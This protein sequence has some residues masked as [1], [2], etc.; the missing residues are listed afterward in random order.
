MGKKSRIIKEQKKRAAEH[1][2]APT[3]LDDEGIH[4][5]VVGQ[6]PGVLETAAI[7]EAYQE[8]IRN[9]G[10]LWDQMVKNFREQ[11]AKEMLN[12]FKVKIEVAP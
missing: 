7:T 6:P 1:V 10:A 2:D 3:W 4:A 12:E 5:I 8:R 9:S 11:K